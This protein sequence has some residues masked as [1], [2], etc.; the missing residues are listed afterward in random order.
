M[1][2]LR[3]HLGDMLG[4]LIFVRQLSILTC[5]RHGDA[6]HIQATTLELFE[7]FCDEHHSC[8]VPRRNHI[9]LTARCQLPDPVVVGLLVEQCR[10]RQRQWITPFNVQF[11][12][13]CRRPDCL[14]K[15]QAIDLLVVVV[16]FV[17]LPMF[18]E[19]KGVDASVCGTRR[20]A[21]R[22]RGGT[23]G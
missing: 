9:H 2:E 20:D 14:R 16:V 12:R 10:Q 8:D 7:K 11:L 3:H 23:R 22:T 19:V 21:G 6:I 13:K 4:V 1:H 17:R 15:R 5:L 18:V